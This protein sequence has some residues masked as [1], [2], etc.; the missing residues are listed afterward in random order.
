ELVELAVLVG[1]SRSAQLPVVGLQP[2]VVVLGGWRHGNPVP[3]EEYFSRAA[4]RE[5][6]FEGVG[7]GAATPVEATRLPAAAGRRVEGAGACG[8]GAH[9]SA[10]EGD[11]QCALAKPVPQLRPRQGT[12]EP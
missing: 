10:V 5:G 8:D 11:G 3:L 12:F 1:A 6:K 2:R 7:R 4:A 9:E